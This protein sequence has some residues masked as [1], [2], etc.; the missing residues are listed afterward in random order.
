MVKKIFIEAIATLM[1]CVLGAGILGIPYVVAQSGFLLGIIWILG[2]GFG[3][4]LINL[5]MGEIVLR[6]K[7]YHQLTGYA[8]KYLGKKGRF[9]MT[10]SM[11]VGI[12][13]ALLAYIIGV[14]N[15]LNAISPYFTSFQYSLIFFITVTLFVLAGLKLIEKLEVGMGAIMIIIASIISIIILF[16]KNFIIENLSTINVSNVFIPYG[17]VLFAYLGTAAIP[18]MHEELHRNK[19]L[20]KKAIIWG[21]IIPII[22]YS[23]FTLV[24]I[25]ASGITTTEI[26]TI[27]LGAI[28]GNYMTIF[29]NLFAVFAMTTSFMCLGLALKGMYTY[30]F[31]L[32]EIS[33]WILTVIVPLILFFIGLNNFIETLWFAGSIAA[34]LAGILI[35]LMHWRCK[36][37]GDKKPEYS[38][39]KNYVIGVILMA[40]FFFGIIYKILK[41]L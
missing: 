34:A 25:G 36:R 28:Y 10:I 33:S 6:T 40:I 15:S 8:E 21:S 2:L 16:S 26:S 23:V 19:K 18:E 7:G 3:I 22:I 37:R 20:F 12:Y 35:V 5:Y 24:V 4:L 41:F 31:K 11:I 39:K 29:A 13:G 30:D 14:G 27:G 1:G 9:F 32:K 17:V 38:I